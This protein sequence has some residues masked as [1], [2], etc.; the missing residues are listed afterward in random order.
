MSINR[1]SASDH[2]PKVAK[3]HSKLAMVKTKNVVGVLLDF[4][5]LVVFITIFVCATY[6]SSHGLTMHAICTEVV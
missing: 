3:P 6:L 1:D 2:G 5:T 4:Y